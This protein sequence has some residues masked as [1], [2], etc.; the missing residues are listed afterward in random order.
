M[1]ASLYVVMGW[2]LMQPLISI[3]SA[4]S[5]WVTGEWV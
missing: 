4:H 5:A 2:S 1:V 3:L